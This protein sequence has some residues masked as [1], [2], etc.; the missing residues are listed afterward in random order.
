MN[1][2]K[3]NQ[4]PKEFYINAIIELMEKCN[5]VPLLDLIYRLLCKHF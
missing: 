1:A 2:N 4:T 3:P 5:D